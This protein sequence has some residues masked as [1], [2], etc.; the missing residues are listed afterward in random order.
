MRMLTIG[1][2]TAGLFAVVGLIAAVPAHAQ[3]SGVDIWAQ[4]CGRCH[5]IQPANRYTA[6]QWETIM[7]Q[8]KIQA[9]M[10]DD[11]AT[12]V[13]EFL[14]SAARRVSAAPTAPSMPDIIAQVAS[15]DPTVGLDSPPGGQVIYDRQCVACHGKSGK[16]DGPAAVALNPR[17]ANLTDAAR[18]AELTDDALER[19]IADGKG[20][21]PGFRALLTSEQLRALT[22]YVRHLSAV[23]GN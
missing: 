1:L 19:L 2:T 20:T 4:T 21:M 15:L 17:P 14:K 11:E 18:M 13:L 7:E 12:A 3:R 10:T 22:A 9:R 8:M 6:D 16:G 23:K 5:L